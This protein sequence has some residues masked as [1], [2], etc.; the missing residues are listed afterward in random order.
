MIKVFCYE[1]SDKFADGRQIECHKKWLTHIKW[2]SQKLTMN[3][4][5]VN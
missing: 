1:R 2:V 5:S 4:L 3:Y